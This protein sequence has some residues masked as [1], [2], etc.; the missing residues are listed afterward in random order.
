M[1][2]HNTQKAKQATH[3]LVLI[4]TSPPTNVDKTLLS[5][6]KNNNDNDHNNINSDIDSDDNKQEIEIIKN[7]K[8]TSS[9]SKEKLK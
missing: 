6:L 4:N 2:S 3:K 7:D 5:D 9:P 1:I 8:S